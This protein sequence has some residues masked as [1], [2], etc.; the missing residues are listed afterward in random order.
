MK[1]KIFKLAAFFIVFKIKTKGYWVVVRDEEK[2]L[3]EFIDA[4]R[5]QNY[6]YSRA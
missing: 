5:K 4:N 1:S 2:K 6:C 3:C